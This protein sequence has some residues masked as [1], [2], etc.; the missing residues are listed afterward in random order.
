MYVMR[1]VVVATVLFSGFAVQA[2]DFAVVQQE[3]RGVKVTLAGK[4]FTEYLVKSGHT[5]QYYLSQIL[6]VLKLI[7]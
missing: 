3:D 6:I 4:T 1:S 2:A 7:L 5:D